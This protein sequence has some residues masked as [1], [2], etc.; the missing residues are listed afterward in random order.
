MGRRF[1]MINFF[2]EKYNYE[3]GGVLYEERLVKDENG[4]IYFNDLLNCDDTEFD[5]ALHKLVDRLHVLQLRR[6]RKKS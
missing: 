4:I 3:V 5:R 1:K 6:E 2:L